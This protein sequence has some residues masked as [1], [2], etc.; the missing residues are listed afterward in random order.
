MN[1]IAEVFKRPRAFLPV[2]H[3]VSRD[4]ALAAVEVAVEAGAD[5]VFLIDQG[6]QER[7]VVALIGEVYRRHPALWVGVNLLSRAPADAL[8]FALAGTGRIDGI[9][10]DNAGIDERAVEQPHA[11]AFVDARRRL[12]WQG[13]YFGGVAFK[14]QREV[15]RAELGRATAIAAA[16][17]DVVCTSGAG[18]GRAADPAKPRAMREGAGVALALASGVT[19][20]NVAEYLPYVDAYLVGTGIERELGVLDPDETKRLATAIHAYLPERG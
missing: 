17:M 3:P 5:G 2:V 18:T 8:A 14:Y 9:W 4:R 6:L 1:R 12:G 16:Y 20:A 15:P 10:S 19:T 13:L 7:E 11:Q